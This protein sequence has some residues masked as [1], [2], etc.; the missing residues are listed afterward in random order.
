M[1]RKLLFSVP[2]LDLVTKLICVSAIN[3]IRM[4]LRRR[5][6]SAK[7]NENR[8]VASNSAPATDPVF[9]GAPSAD[10]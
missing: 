9:S 8:H 3:A 4:Q 5:K 7:L 6:N 2:R 1:P 10:A